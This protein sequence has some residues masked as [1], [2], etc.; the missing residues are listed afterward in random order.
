MSLRVVKSGAFDIV[1]DLGRYGFQYLG[2]NPGGAMDTI[3]AQVSNMLVG[4]DINDAIIELHFPASSFLFE[5]DAVIALSGADF[6]AVCNTY[7]LPLNTPVVIKKYSLLQFTKYNSG[8]RC[9]LAVESG[10]DLPK[11]LNSYSTHLKVKTGGFNGRCLNKDD[12]L[13]IKKNHDYTG[14]LKEKDCLALPWKAD[15]ASLYS[16]Q[17]TLRVCSGPEYNSL[18]DSSKKEFIFSSFTITNQSDRMG[19]RMQGESLQ[20]HHRVELISSAVSKG[21]IQLLPNG[22]LIILMAD[23]QTTGGYPGIAHVISADIPSLAQRQSNETIQFKIIDHSE[24]EEL[25]WQQ[26]QYFQVLQNACTL[27]LTKFFGEYVH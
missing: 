1:Q 21:T 6:G 24:A 22:Q 15:I 13:P 4:N 9:Y 14:V 7:S 8:A 12:E 3:A 25:L 17:K 2:I 16:T 26:H 5:Q 23:H 19:Y 11:W 27:Q 18:T 10:F 20:L